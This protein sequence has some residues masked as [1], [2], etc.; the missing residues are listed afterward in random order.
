VIGF[1][2]QRVFLD[3][4]YL[5]FKPLPLLPETDRSIVRPHNVL[6]LEINDPTHLIIST[7]RKG[8]KTWRYTLHTEPVDRSQFET[9]WRESFGWKS[10]MNSHVLTRIRNDDMIIYL[11][12][13]L[14]SV[15]REHRTQ[16]SVPE[17]TTETSYIAELFGL[18]E[19]L[20]REYKLEIGT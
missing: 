10:V 17:G 9:A 18:D 12:G 7:E 20:I 1:P 16:L 6:H 3:P 8:Q 5:C 4:G 15:T 13:R 2:N 14:E 11:D 19:T